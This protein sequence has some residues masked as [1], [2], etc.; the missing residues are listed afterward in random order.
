MFVD[1]STFETPIT[2]LAKKRHMNLKETAFVH[3]LSSVLGF[4][5]YLLTY[6]LTEDPHGQTGTNGRGP[7][8]LCPAAHSVLLLL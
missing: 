8:A 5:S 3:L 6:L 2:Y 1:S 4:Y 7:S